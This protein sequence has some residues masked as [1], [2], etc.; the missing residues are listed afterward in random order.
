[1]PTLKTP[2]RKTVRTPDN[3]SSPTFAPSPVPWW[4]AAISTFGVPAAIAMYLVYVLTTGQTQALNTVAGK[5][6]ATDKKTA[7]IADIVRQEL[8]M[9][10]ARIEGYLRIL[11]VNGAKTQPERNACLTVR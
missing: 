6:D 2:P 9:S 5:L 1:M 7:A 8:V 3:F 4:V 11:C 10:N